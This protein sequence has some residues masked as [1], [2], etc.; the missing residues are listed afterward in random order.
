MRNK[1]TKP[2]IISFIMLVIF[3]IYNVYIVNGDI[4]NT[5]I[6]MSIT[7]IPILYSFVPLLKQKN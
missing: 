1:S 2:L 4:I 5:V 3:S 6:L 7:L